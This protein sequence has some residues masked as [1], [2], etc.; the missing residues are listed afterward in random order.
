MNVAQGDCSD[1]RAAAADKTTKHNR[2]RDMRREG[3]HRS[4]AFDMLLTLPY[5]LV[6]RDELHAMW[7]EAGE[8]AE[9]EKQ[10]RV[11]ENVSTW[12]SQ[13]TSQ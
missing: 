6:L 1:K 4:D 2:E 13:V 11:Q 8:K 5:I 3:R 12:A 9:A 10:R 7:K